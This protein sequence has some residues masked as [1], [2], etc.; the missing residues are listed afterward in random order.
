MQSPDVCKGEWIAHPLGHRIQQR[1]RQQGCNK[2]TGRASKG[3]LD[4][5]DSSKIVR[6]SHGVKMIKLHQEVSK[7]CHEGF[8][9]DTEII[10]RRVATWTNSCRKRVCSQKREKHFEN[11]VSDNQKIRRRKR[12][13]ILSRHATELS[14]QEHAQ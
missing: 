2:Q 5:S 4:T 14:W 10:L 1:M 12:I 6:L 3:F 9:K 13:K 8:N 11:D 7:M